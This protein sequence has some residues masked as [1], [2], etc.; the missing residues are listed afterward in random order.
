MTA[1]LIMSNVNSTS[2]ELIV[3][4]LFH[5]QGFSVIVIVLSPLD[6]VGGFATLSA[7]STV[8]VEPLRRVVQ[9]RPHLATR[10]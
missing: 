3:W 4:P 9:R 5:F 6:H 8:G 2:L 7:G 1:A 10:S